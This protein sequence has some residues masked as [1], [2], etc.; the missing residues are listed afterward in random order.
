MDLKSVEEAF[1]RLGLSTDATKKELKRAYRKK[2]TIHHPD[3][4][5]GDD[6]IQSEIND[7]YRIA[8]EF[9]KNKKGIVPYRIEKSLLHVEHVLAQQQALLRANEKAK[10]LTRN[11]TSGLNRLK[12]LMWILGAVAGVVALFGNTLFPIL[13]PEGSENFLTLRLQ[14]AELTFTLGILGL[15]LQ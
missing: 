3:K 9:F 6:A 1:S 15:F 11:K 4:S 7:A 14:F 2:C 13:V 12:Y 10:R 8:T 5:G